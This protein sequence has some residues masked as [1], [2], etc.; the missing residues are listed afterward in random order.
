MCRVRSWGSQNVRIRFFEL[1]R[2]T[3]L[4]AFACSLVPPLTEVSI[5]KSP[6]NLEGRLG[7]TL[8]SFDERFTRTTESRAADAISFLNTDDSTLIVQFTGGKTP[9]PE[10]HAYFILVRAPRPPELPASS[11]ADS[12]WTVEAAESV[13]ATLL[14]V[15]V[16]LG[17]MSALDD[18]E[19]GATCSSELLA[20]SMGD[21]AGGSCRMSFLLSSPDTVSFITLTATDS[22]GITAVTSNPC[23]GLVAWAKST[24]ARL[25]ASRSILAATSLQYE[26]DPWAASRLWQLAAQ[27]SDLA[28]EQASS[29]A[30]LSVAWPSDLLTGA[31]NSY[32]SALRQ[33]AT[34]LIGRDQNEIAGAID[35]INGA[36]AD[37]EHARTLIEP[38]LAECGIAS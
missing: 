5:A 30:P 18:Q 31:F 25:D 26:A 3:L 21:A 6:A 28:S 14:P 34:G 17:E 37:V 33:V 36:N 7:G 15:D 22:T 8:S 38:P 20:E 27:F 9:K 11:P 1:G 23:E 12:D 35:L 19:I 10:D 32:A 29:E 2:L 13:A 4:I 24:S 16:Q